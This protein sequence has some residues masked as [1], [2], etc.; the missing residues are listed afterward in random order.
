[1][2]RGLDRTEPLG[3]TRVVMRANQL[4]GAYAREVLER[5]VHSMRF[6]FGRRGIWSAESGPG[7]K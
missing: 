1:M 4:L 3:A 2:L 6:L 7:V 5:E